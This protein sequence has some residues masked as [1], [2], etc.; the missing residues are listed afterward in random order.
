MRKQQSL[1]EKNMQPMEKADNV[2][3]LSG[4]SLACQLRYYNYPEMKRPQRKNIE[5]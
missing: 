3:T 4:L 1:S 2:K 5:Q